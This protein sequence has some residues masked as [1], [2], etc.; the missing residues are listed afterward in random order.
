MRDWQV[1]SDL[2][3]FVIH[4]DFFDEGCE[5]ELRPLN[6]A[7]GKSLTKITSKLQHP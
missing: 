1:V 7:R 3:T 6:I 5:E 2:D 4:I